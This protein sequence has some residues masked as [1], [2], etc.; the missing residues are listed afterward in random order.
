MGR[1][2]ARFFRLMAGLS[3]CALSIVITINANIGVS[4]WEVLQ[5]GMSETM[6]I[7]YGN[8]NIIVGL[9]ILAADILMKEKVGVGTFINILY[10]GKAADFLIAA[11]IVPHNPSGNIVFGLGMMTVGLALLAVGC[12]LY[13]GAA[14]G[15]GPRDSMMVGLK[16]RFNKV[17]VGVL[18]GFLEGAAV[19]GGW[20]LGGKVGV[21]TI[22]S[23]V[24]TG[25]AIQTVFGICKFKVD[26][27]SQESIP[28]TM[29]YILRALSG[30]TD[31][32]EEEQHTPDTLSPGDEQSEQ[33]SLPLHFEA[34]ENDSL[35]V[36][37]ASEPEYDT[38]GE[39]SEQAERSEVE[40]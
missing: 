14:L 12:F 35:L 30:K 24:G 15:A 20:M 2:G 10:V 11:D 37:S 7:T 3:V 27:V 34:A 17:P 19:L 23:I 18:R 31:K 25:F 21:G 32:K 22:Y 5:L 40:V 8:A 33:T 38:L 13:V 29:A 6:G 9:V 39:L 1:Y 36:N 16:K 26:E 4:P 28:D